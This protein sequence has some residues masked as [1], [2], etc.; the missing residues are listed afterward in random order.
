MTKAEFCLCLFSEGSFVMHWAASPWSKYLE[1]TW[2]YFSVSDIY[3]K[4]FELVAFGIKITL[5]ICIYYQIIC[6]T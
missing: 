5:N 2:A 1:N 3:F 6:S 4:R